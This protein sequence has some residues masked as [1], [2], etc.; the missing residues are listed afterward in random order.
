MTIYASYEQSRWSPEYS[1]HLHMCHSTLLL[2]LPIT[3]VTTSDLS[4]TV[5]RHQT[6]WC[7]LL[8]TMQASCVPKGPI[9]PP[10][11]AIPRA[12]SIKPLL[13][14]ALRPDCSRQHCQNLPLRPWWRRHR[15]LWNAWWLLLQSPRVTNT[16]PVQFSRV[17]PVLP[18]TS[19][20]GRRSPSLNRCS[21]WA[22]RSSV[23]WLISVSW[24]KP[25]L[26]K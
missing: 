5:I 11:S 14:E 8:P 13:M 20:I 18:T 25:T 21:M 26:R 24:R 17:T 2:P 4:F 3:G 23:H 9:W 22:S 7:N 19:N 16:K 6:R 1:V 12:C 10:C 15:R